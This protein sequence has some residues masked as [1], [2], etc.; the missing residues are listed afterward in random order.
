MASLKYYQSQCEK[1]LYCLKPLLHQP[2]EGGVTFSALFNNITK[3]SISIFL[4]PII[5]YFLTFV[6][7]NASIILLY[8]T[9]FIIIFY[10]NIM[11][12]V[13]IKIKI[14][15]EFLCNIFCMRKADVSTFKLFSKH[16]N[17]VHIIFKQH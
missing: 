11:C 10:L 1:R 12:R 9:C 15:T 16:H 17:L 3:S 13:S 7:T 14:Y 2:L 6:N 8:I 5:Y 4:I